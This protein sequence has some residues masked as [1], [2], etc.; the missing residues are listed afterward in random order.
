MQQTLHEMSKYIPIP[1]ASQSYIQN[2]GSNQLHL[3]VL[4]PLSVI[5]KLAILTNKPVGTKIHIVNNTIQ[6]H[7][8]TM[9][10]GIYR[11]WMNI[12]KTDIYY[13]YHPIIIAC[14]H[15]LVPSRSDY[16]QLVHLFK[17][18]K[19]GLHMLIDTYK[20]CR[21]IS[22]CIDYYLHIIE[23]HIQ[24]TAQEITDSYSIA[25]DIKDLYTPSRITQ[26]ANV[27]T[28]EQIKVVLNLIQFLETDQLATVN[29]K[30]LETIVG[31][32]DHKMSTIH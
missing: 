31:G 9:F 27:W 4:D 23:S 3:F 20:Q 8:P 25:G 6:L 17:Y 29:V 16:D 12:H 5:I 11:Y 14:S 19:K 24:G 22:V 30:S 1:F 18:A 28:N 15:Y 2:D 21:I 26:M 32:I 13:L 10:Q 7:E